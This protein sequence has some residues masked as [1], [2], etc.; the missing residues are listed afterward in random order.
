MSGKSFWTAC[1]VPVW[2]RDAKSALNWVNTAYAA[3]AGAKNREEAVAKQIELFETRQRS[4]LHRLSQSKK[5]GRVKL[6]TVVNGGVQIYEAIPA[7]LERGA[8]ERRSMWH[9]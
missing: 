7:P 6:Q 4:E 5:Q 9:R 2:L 3:A 8:A 1:P